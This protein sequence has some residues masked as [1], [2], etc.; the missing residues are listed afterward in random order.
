MITKFECI[1]YAQIA[2][3]NIITKDKE[4]NP[5]SL[6]NEMCKLLDI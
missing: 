1:C 3:L 2:I 4:I 5:F 6:Y